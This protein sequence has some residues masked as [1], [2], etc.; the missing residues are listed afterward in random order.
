MIQTKVDASLRGLQRALVQEGKIIAFTSRALTDTEKCYA[1][2][3]HEMLA[4]V[5]ACEKFHPYISNKKFTVESSHPLEMIHL[6][7][8]TAVPPRLQQMLLRIQEYHMKLST[9]LKLNCFLLTQCQDSIPYPV[10]NHCTY[11][12]CAWCNSLTRD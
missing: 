10:T 11:K 1:N 7:N 4:V 6:E 12:K 8:L 5:V 2:I 3:G 9:N